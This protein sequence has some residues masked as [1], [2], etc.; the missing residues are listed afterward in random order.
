M[1]KSSKYYSYQHAAARN[2]REKWRNC[3]GGIRCRAGA[4]SWRGETRKAANVSRRSNIRHIYGG[5]GAWR[6]GENNRKQS[7]SGS[8]VTRR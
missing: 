1:A 8:G 7:G 3:A 6:V 5:A 4:R 2:L